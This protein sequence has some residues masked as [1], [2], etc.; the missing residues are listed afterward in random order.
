LD[1]AVKTTKDEEKIRF[2]K[3]LQSIL[4]EDAAAVYIQDPAL[5]VAV[6]KK[7]DGFTF[8]PVFALD[9]ASVYYAE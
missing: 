3:E 9:M 4:A 8:Y 7:L 5:L 6:N 2:Y 1:N